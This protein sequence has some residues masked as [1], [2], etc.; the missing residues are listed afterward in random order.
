MAEAAVRVAACLC[1]LGWD[2]R[3]GEARGMLELL[4][5]AQ[6]GGREGAS[7]AAQGAAGAPDAGALGGRGQ[8]DREG[9]TAL[10]EEGEAAIL[11]LLADPWFA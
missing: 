1:A 11:Q 4:L 2:E 6:E 10:T 7:A 5:E 3:M 9:D 8:V